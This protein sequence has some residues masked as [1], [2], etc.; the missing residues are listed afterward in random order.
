MSALPTSTLPSQKFPKFGPCIVT[1]RKLSI[2]FCTASVAANDGLSEDRTR[3]I[4]FRQLRHRL[5]QLSHVLLRH[6]PPSSVRSPTMSRFE[7]DIVLH[8]VCEMPA[9][10]PPVSCHST[11]F[12]KSPLIERVV[13][14]LSRSLDSGAA[15]VLTPSSVP[16]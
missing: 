7:G 13:E 14:H 9:S 11:H 15:Q 10:A 1:H 12:V 16:A 3:H 6:T 4:V 5:F 8:F 2:T